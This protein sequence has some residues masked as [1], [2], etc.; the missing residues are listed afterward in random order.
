[1]L[2]KVALQ[3]PM[4]LYLELENIKIVSIVLLGSFDLLL[5]LLILI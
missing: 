2:F 3:E 4:G 1:M 5:A